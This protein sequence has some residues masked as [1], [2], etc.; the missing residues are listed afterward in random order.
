MKHITKEESALADVYTAIH[1]SCVFTNKLRYKK[2]R[3]AQSEAS[4]LNMRKW[5]CQCGSVH[6]RDVNAAKN[7]RDE[8]LRILAEGYPAT[9]SGR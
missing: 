9:A 4:R 2:R 7:I 6:D 8:G 1:K 5:T 3:D